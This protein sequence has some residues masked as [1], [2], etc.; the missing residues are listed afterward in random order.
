MFVIETFVQIQ[1]NSDS[2]VKAWIGNT[3]RIYKT[4]EEITF[5]THLK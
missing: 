2:L 5:L 1:I 3:E 4:N